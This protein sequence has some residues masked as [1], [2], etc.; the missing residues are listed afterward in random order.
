MMFSPQGSRNPSRRADCAALMDGEAAEEC[1]ILE[2]IASLVR[3]LLAL[4]R[5]A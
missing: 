4:V 5:S 3:R 2:A 1:R